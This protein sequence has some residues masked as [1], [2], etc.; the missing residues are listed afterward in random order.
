[1]PTEVQA[2]KILLI[3]SVEEVDEN[4]FAPEIL[5]EWIKKAEQGVD[6]AWFISRAENLL[7]HL[8]EAYD[9]ILEMA[10][11]PGKGSTLIIGALGL[12]LGLATNYLGPAGKIHVIY[13]PILIF[14]AWNLFAY[15]FFA[16]LAIWGKLGR[17]EQPKRNEQDQVSSPQPSDVKIEKDQP[18]KF[19]PL[20]RWFLRNVFSPLWSKWFKTTHEIAIEASTFT[21]IAGHFWGSWIKAAGPLLLHRWRR[22]LHSL[23]LSIAIGAIIG[24][25]L[26]SLFLEY[27]VV[28]TSTFIK[29]EDVVVVFINTIFLPA[30]LISSLLGL[31][32]EAT[33]NIDRLMSLGG[34][35]AAPWIHL[36]SITAVVIIMLPRAV[37]MLWE[38]RQVSYLAK[39]VQ[40]NLDVGVVEEHMKREILK[41]AHIASDKLS[42]GIATFVSE[43]LYD[44]RIVPEM[45]QFR[46]EGGKIVD[47][48]NRI[49]LVCEDFSPQIKSYMPTAIS[50]FERS[51]A[52]GVERLVKGLRTD[53]GVAR[54][55]SD[56]L[57]TAIST[58]SAQTIDAST[59]KISHGFTDTVSAVV[60]V[61]IGFAFATICG[62]LGKTVGLTILATFLGTTGPVGF[63]IGGIAGIVVGF[64]GVKFGRKKI[65]KAVETVPMPGAVLRK[66]LWESRFRSL[67]ENGRKKCYA[68]VKEQIGNEMEPQL[69]KLSENIWQRL[70]QQFK[71]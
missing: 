37:F 40:I 19:H 66:V 21:K 13:N 30:F 20:F 32:L 61:S 67:I 5:N 58:E 43:R 33:V 65:T 54:S 16:C 29:S 42:A 69:Q 17:H 9:S 6:Q 64:T 4:A 45:E 39:N 60:T 59:T 52:A 56:D 28:W 46:E 57:P 63:L 55:A 47:L 23:A 49:K 36:F 53:F 10:R 70:D 12:I 27:E 24:M 68:S 14:V 11:F 1:M 8:R 71:Q 34:D 44:E 26:R 7:E 18:I 35:P 48:K 25:Y 2:A 50:D 22:V 62:G 51:L 15:L 31:D 38:G 3:R 41:E